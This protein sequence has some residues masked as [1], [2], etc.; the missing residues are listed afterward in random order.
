MSKLKEDGMPREDAGHDDWEFENRVLALRN[1]LR[2]IPRLLGQVSEVMLS[3]SSKPLSHASARGESRPMPGGRALEVLAPVADYASVP[4]DLPHPVTVLREVADLVREWMG[5]PS[6][7]SESM[8]SATSFVEEHARYVVAHEDLH[9]WVRAKLDGVLGLLRSLVGDTERVEP[10]TI[11][12]SEVRAHMSELLDHNPG[13]YW[14]TPAQ[15]EKFW[16]GIQSRIK[17][18]RSRARARAKAESDRRSRKAGHRVDVE[19]VYFAVPDA[20]GRYPG[21]VLEAF[22]RSAGHDRTRRV[23]EGACAEGVES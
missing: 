16:T 17:A 8:R 6:I 5:R 23:L 4:D 9:T 19:P 12:L 10:R 20:Q 2:E 11:D 22:H 13:A 7:P 15:A 18:H 3:I 1:D 14:M 21:D